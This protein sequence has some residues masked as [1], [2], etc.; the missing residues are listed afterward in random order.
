[1][2]SNISPARSHPKAS[3]RPTHGTAA[4]STSCVGHAVS[5]MAAGTCL[6]VR[7]LTFVDK[8]SP[9]VRGLLTDKPLS[10]AVVSGIR[11]NMEGRD[12]SPNRSTHIIH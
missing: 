3:G 8:V 2:V 11:D 6:G 7:M 1:M 12:Y 4:P 10:L 5:G 9:V